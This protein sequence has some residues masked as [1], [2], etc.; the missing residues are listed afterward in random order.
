MI[1]YQIGM[2]A[3]HP[4]VWKFPGGEV[5]VTALPSNQAHKVELVTIIA[6]IQ[7]SDE[8]MQLFMLTDA[9][10]RM[11]YNAKINLRLGYVPYGRQDRVCNEGESLSISVFAALVNSQ[12]Y[13]QVMIFDP[14]SD[15]TP[16]L[17]NRVVVIKQDEIYDEVFGSR[18]DLHRT[19]VAPDV[20]AAKK[21]SCIGAMHLMPVVYANKTRDLSN[22]NITDLSFS[23]DVEGKDV[24]VVDDICDGGATF[25]TLGQKL[26][27]RGVK[28]MFLFVTHGIFSK[29]TDVLTSI[30]DTV[31][32]T[33]TYH[34]DRDGLVDGV[35]Y[36][37]LI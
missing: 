2:I 34:Q 22:G 19:L 11:Y 9:L 18:F 26:R 4:K 8:I 1:T 6:S 35:F 12:N 27:E 28:N 20:G 31:Y 17:F 33:N 24:I 29:G 5:G 37:K 16:A 32:T 21:S 3:Y 15:V 23:G 30:Y 14:H 7:S 36:H 25:V 10:R 13:N